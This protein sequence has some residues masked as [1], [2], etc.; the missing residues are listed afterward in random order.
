MIPKIIHYCW[1]G[2]APKSALIERCMASWRVHLPDYEIVE[3]NEQ[4]FDVNANLYVTQ[5]Y[6]TRKWAF[7]SDYVRLYAIANHGGIYLDTDVEVFRS[8]DRFLQHKAFTGFE[9]F[10]GAMSPI[11]AVMGARQN[12]PWIRELLAEYDQ[13]AFLS[14]K[15]GSASPY[16]NTRR[17]TTNLVERYG[18]RIDDTAQV[19]G[20]D[21][22]IYPS[23][24]FCNYRPGSYSM[25]H[26]N[27][28][29]I[30]WQYKLRA[31]LKDRALAPLG[32]FKS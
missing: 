4:R 31:W 14:S 17:I 2:G 11:T 1:F 29:W 15:D 32:L 30:P 23:H 25:H 6:G 8:F 12:H 18:V 19:V 9:N 20:D 3:W 5:A 10:K 7:V 21:L 16:T 22:H 26:F 13:A 27:G 24:T 28:S